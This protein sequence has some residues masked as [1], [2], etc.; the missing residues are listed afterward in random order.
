VR[1][2]DID[3]DGARVVYLADQ[4][5]DE[6]SE[7]WSVPIDGSSAAVKISGALAADGDVVQCGSDVHPH[8]HFTPDGS[9]FLYL[10]DGNGSGVLRL[11]G[12]PTDGN[13]APVELSGPMVAGGSVAFFATCFQLTP[14]GQRV[15]YQADQ[16][17]DEVYELYSA[18]TDGSALPVKLNGALVAGG[19]VSQ[20]FDGVHLSPA[21]DRVVYRADA[22]ADEVHELFS[23][24]VDGSTAPVKLCGTLV[25]GG[26][27]SPF[28]RFSL[29]G[30]QVV[31]RADALVNERFDVFS[32][33]V[34][35]SLAP[36]PLSA[37]PAANRSVQEFAVG[38][39][40]ALVVYR[41][42]QDTDQVFELYTAPIDGAAPPVKIAGACQSFRIGPDDRDVV[43]VAFGGSFAL[44]HVP[45]LGAF[46]PV[47]VSGPMAGLGVSAFSF[48]P[49]GERVVYLADQDVPAIEE[50]YASFLP[51]N[52]APAAAPE[53]SASVGN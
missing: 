28:V 48:T 24:P 10:A 19:D 39:D 26:D 37:L 3:P 49:G 13:S 51:R 40:G 17:T 16:T 36:V 4:E 31:Y 1:S 32:V 44:F 50:L 42:D 5:T 12:V 14:S 6:Q 38:G 21:G 46:E 43:F 29:D 53:R 45:M 9:R 8:A 41:A 33:P 30:S 22:N 11:F 27:V 20:G 23:V 18:P 47:R 15:V 2:F 7:L 25:T 34:D 52:H 35:G